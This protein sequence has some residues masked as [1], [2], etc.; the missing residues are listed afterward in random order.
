MLAKFVLTSYVNQMVSSSANSFSRKQDGCLRDGPAVPL[1]QK[2]P[3]VGSG[4]RRGCGVRQECGVA[5]GGR[6]EA[7]GISLDPSQVDVA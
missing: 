4:R 6:P 2:D 5:G 1:G 7:Y 3:L